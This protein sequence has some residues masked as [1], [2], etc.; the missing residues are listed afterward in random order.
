MPPDYPEKMMIDE[1][2]VSNRSHPIKVLSYGNAATQ[3][4]LCMQ[5][6]DGVLAEQEE[7]NCV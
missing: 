4:T 7:R 1:S 5:I 3:K 6:K 2:V